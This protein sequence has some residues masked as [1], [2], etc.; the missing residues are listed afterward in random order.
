LTQKIEKI[1]A[2][3]VDWVQIREK[4]LKRAARLAYQQ[5][6]RAAA[7]SSPGVLPPLASWSMI[8]LMWPSPSADGV[9]LARGACRLKKPTLDSP[10][11]A[12]GVKPRGF[13]HGR[14]LSFAGIRA[15]R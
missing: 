2:A 15:S 6:L 9:H 10:S 3:D 13:P 11:L 1:V 12:E 8:G 5:A 7:G 4:D 14:V